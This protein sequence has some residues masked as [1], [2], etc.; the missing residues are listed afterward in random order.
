MHAARSAAPAATTTT[1]LVAVVLVLVLIAVMGAR[2][3]DGPGQVWR[4]GWLD[5]EQI[6]LLEDGRYQMQVWSCVGSDET[7][8]S[9][10]W[11]P[12][13][14]VVSLVPGTPG[15]PPRL[16]RKARIDDDWYLYE[17]TPTGDRPDPDTFYRLL[18]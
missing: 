14:E 12:L 15:H 1:I 4:R 5:G 11:S 10:S 16:M 7:I 3:D 6:R 18:D 8:E 9:G 13:A 2:S 17:P